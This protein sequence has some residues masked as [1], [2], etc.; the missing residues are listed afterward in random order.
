MLGSIA[1]AIG[2]GF[3]CQVAA[4]DDKLTVYEKLRELLKNPDSLLVDE[5]IPAKSS[6]Q[7][8]L[9]DY[10]P[11]NSKNLAIIKK[12]R[13]VMMAGDFNSDDYDLISS[14]QNRDIH[15]QGVMS[16]TGDGKGKTTSALGWALE[17]VMEGKSA[18]IA[19]WFKEKSWQIS[20]HNFP[21]FLKE[22]AQLEFYTSGA[23]FFE[24]PDNLV[25]EKNFQIH[26]QK[27]LEGI[28]YLC[29]NE[30]RF[31]AFVLDEFVD[32]SSEISAN[33]SRSLLEAEEI[34]A[35]LKRFSAGN[36]A[37]SGRRVTDDWVK[38]IKTAVEI[39]NIKHP[40]PERKAIR[41]MDF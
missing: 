8:L 21:G 36:T 5:I 39:E 29:K 13:H 18:L 40:F 31:Q 37:V 34:N 3:Q 2:F 10:L 28:D 23:G 25:K 7:L 33:I 19:Q 35:V 16:F 11:L 41:G 4:A 15:K 26:R 9:I 24:A 12:N 38:H 32:T 20:E 22:P 17:K 27:A 6:A 30:N 1:R 14:F